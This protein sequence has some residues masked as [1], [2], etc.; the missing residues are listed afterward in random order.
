MADGFEPHG[1]IYSWDMPGGCTWVL[2]AAAVGVPGVVGMWWVPGRAIPVPTQPVPRTPILVYL[3][4]RTL[5][6]AK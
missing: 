5:P 3:R 4:L 2:V 6:T 1:H